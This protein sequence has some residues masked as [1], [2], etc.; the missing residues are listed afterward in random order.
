MAE[1]EYLSWDEFRNSGML[2]EVNRQFFHPLGLSLKIL[3]DDEGEVTGIAGIAD[4][5][6]NPQGAIFA[7]VGDDHRKRANNI[8][9]EQRRRAAM[10]ETL[11]GFVRQPIPGVNDET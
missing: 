8:I 1:P 11:L 3:I 5:R 9:G 6:A 2:Q 4:L 10:R 7:D